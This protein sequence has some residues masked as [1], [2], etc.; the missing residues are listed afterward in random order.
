[1]TD[2][3]YEYV[4]VGS[5]PGGGT[6]AARLAEAGRSVLLL[7]AGGD[8]LELAG[9]DA[10]STSNRLPAD[11]DVPAFHAFAS[12]ND[13]M[14]WHFFVGHH[15]DKSLDADD[16]N[17]VRDFRG[18]RVD[19]FYYPRAG[20]LGGCSAHN[21]MIFVAPDDVDWDGIAGLT[22]DPTWRASNMRQY[23]QRVEDCRYRP[24]Q[25][26]LGKLGINP[27][28]HGWH[29]WLP[30]EVCVPM[31]SLN[32]ERLDTLLVGALVEAL[33]EDGKRWPRLRALF[34]GAFDAN[35][36]RLAKRNDVGARF[37]PITTNHH[38]R[39]GS[40]ER[41]RDVQRRFP[42]RLTVRLNA[43]ATRV[44]FDRDNRAVGVE[45][46]RGERLYR[47]HARP[48]TDASLVESVYASRE[49]IL[50]GGAFNS[51]QLLMLSG[52]GPA[53][54]LRDRGVPVRVPLDGVGTGLQDR[55]EVSVVNEMAFPKWS[56][57]KGATFGTDDP[58][59]A[60]WKSGRAGVYAT[61]GSVLTITHRSPSDAHL[62]NLF[63]M[64]LL[65]RFEGYK[66]AYSKTFSTDLNYLTWVVLKSHTT[67]RG[68]TVRLRSNDPRDTPTVEFCQFSDGGDDDVDALVEGIRFVRRLTRK[69]KAQELIA[70]ETVPGSDKESDL[71]LQEFVRTHAWGHHACGTCAIG[72]IDEGGVL[73]SDFTVHGTRGLRVVDASVFPRIPGFFIVSAVY[74]IA[75][76]AAD[77]ILARM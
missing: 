36:W 9:G 12:E 41:V 23:F 19:G 56:V 49:V 32:D 38:V 26:W 8:P 11:Y 57:Y 74:M 45:Y 40:R 72:S 34:K 30:T 66:P 47:A 21:A 3:A 68:G 60:Q 5:G 51:P 22:G 2:A 46:L 43:L 59:F 18:Q 44:I 73:A 54:H 52:I 7:E 16:P 15:T 53:G 37:T 20:T 58:Q 25:R 13:A 42:D 61:N 31:A 50:S 76:K 10:L 67:N 77:V 24:L 1:M 71:A 55:Y 4:V 63:C 69:L 17:F 39:V 29:G 35:D 70:R 6:L 14:A 62:P 28:G 75:E 48:S 65:A 33:K 27:S 64:A